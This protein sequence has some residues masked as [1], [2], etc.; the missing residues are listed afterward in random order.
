MQLMLDHVIV[1][2]VILVDVPL[3]S[4]NTPVRRN[5]EI[6]PLIILKGGEGNDFES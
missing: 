6:P 1:L 5:R 4:R 2:P 3:V